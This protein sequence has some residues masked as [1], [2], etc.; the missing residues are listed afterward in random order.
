LLKYGWLV[1]LVTYFKSCVV[2]IRKACHVSN[3]QQ[4]TFYD[5]K[6]GL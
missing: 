3:I 5:I 4:L 1:R 2:T 6:D